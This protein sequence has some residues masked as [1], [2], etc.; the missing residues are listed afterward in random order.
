MSRLTITL[1]EDM[2]TQIDEQA[3]DSGPY[4]SKSEAVRELIRKGERLAEVERERD[5]LREQ[6]AAQNSRADDV[7]ELV[8]YVEHERALRREERRRRSAPIWERAKW[9][10]FGAPESA[11]G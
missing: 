11:E 4:D 10:V 9:W 8:E 1:P 2:A 3:G 6:L 7:E 5:R